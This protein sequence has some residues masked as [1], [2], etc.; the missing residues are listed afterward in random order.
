MVYICIP[1]HNEERTIG[2]LL[3]KIRRVMVDFG[4]DFEILVLNDASTDETGQLLD[5]YRRVV[6]LHVLTERTRIGYS[7]A[8]EKLLRESVKRAAYPK[9]DAAITLQADFSEDPAGMVPL[10]KSLEGGADIVAGVL[11][12]D[13]E[14]QPRSARLTR[15][16]ARILLRGTLRTSPVSDPLNGFR[17]YRVI[18]L[19]KAFRAA[20]GS[21]FLRGDGW[22]ANLEILGRLVP[23]ARRVEDAVLEES[24]DR[25]VRQSRFKALKTLR[26]LR[27]VRNRVRFAPEGGPVA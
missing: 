27:S 25:R 14:A 8:T 23:H 24:P 16:L 9:R 26:S 1:A 22:A 7:A 15:W 20:E 21:E 17:A 13:R 6:P 2:V 11:G 5:E 18:V 10:I 19:K 4:R 12:T 3:W